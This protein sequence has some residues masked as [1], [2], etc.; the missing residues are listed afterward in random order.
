MDAQ[1]VGGLA[2]LLGSLT[3]GWVLA[4]V[5]GQPTF[6]RVVPLSSTLSV[7]LALQAINWL[8]DLNS[9]A[10]AIVS[11]VVIAAGVAASFM[12]RRGQG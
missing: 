12:T 10:L 1:T 3:S 9:A 4:L 5:R 7:A 11:I 2:S 8:A 6:R